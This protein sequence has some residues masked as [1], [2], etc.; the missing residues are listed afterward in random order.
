LAVAGALASSAFAAAPTKTSFSFTGIPATLTGVCSFDVA[1]SADVSGFEIDYT[2]QS[3]ALTR[4]YDHV[5]EQDTFSANGKSITG[6][7]YTTDVET[8]FDS[9]GNVT[10][11]YGSGVAERLVLPSGTLFLS[12]G[13]SDFTLH[14]GV[15]FLLSPDVGNP[16]DV[17]AFCAAL[18]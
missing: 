10:H 7:P 13:R 6:Q 9:S 5:T 15:A 4:I 1:L 16:G 14:P 11:V 3:G 18:S 2:D 8:L 12:A 17:A